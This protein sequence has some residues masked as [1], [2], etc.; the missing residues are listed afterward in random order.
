LHG[1]LEPPTHRALRLS[2]CIRSV[3]LVLWWGAPHRR[4]HIGRKYMPSV[5]NEPAHVPAARGKMS[6]WHTSNRSVALHTS[7]RRR[8][9]LRTTDSGWGQSGQRGAE[10]SWGVMQR[11][12]GG[13][14]SRRDVL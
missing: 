9:A 14:P 2:F 7:W 13:T 10:L 6:G 1:G 11:A 4:Q 8:W 5:A 3:S 12:F